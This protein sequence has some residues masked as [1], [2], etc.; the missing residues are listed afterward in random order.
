MYDAAE[1]ARKKELNQA[2]KDRMALK[3]FESMG[4]GKADLRRRENVKERRYIQDEIDR[5]EREEELKRNFDNVIF[6]KEAVDRL[7]ADDPT[8]A[9]D[10]ELLK[11]LW[12]TKSE[13]TT[14]GY[15]RLVKQKQRRE[16]VSKVPT[17]VVLPPSPPLI[18]SRRISTGA[19]RGRQSPLL[20]L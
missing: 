16:A 9:Y 18:P 15:E 4:R 11:I 13:L 7:H 20:C 10:E 8:M 6:Y 5:E 2:A 14:T 17:T 12:A 19:K 1:E 3:D